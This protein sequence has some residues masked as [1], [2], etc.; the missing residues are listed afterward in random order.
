MDIWDM[1]ADQRRELANV[2]DRLDEAQWRTDSLCAGWTVRD[3]AGHVI[4]PFKLSMPGIMMRLMVNGFNFNKTLFKTAKT[5]GQRPTSELVSL[6][7]ENAESHWT[8]PKLGPEAPLSDIVIHTQ[9]VCRPL[10]LEQEIAG[11][12]LH[13]ILDFITSPA[14]RVFADTRLLEGLHLAPDNLDWSWGDGPD[15]QGPAEAMM[16]VM[17]GRAAAL[18]DLYGTGVDLLRDRL[19]TV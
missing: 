2:F 6:L 11:E 4:T 17:V 18:E 13:R 14:A 16:M 15:V 7:R 5:L 10:G 9:D 12:K 8:P 3:V 1:I 19:T